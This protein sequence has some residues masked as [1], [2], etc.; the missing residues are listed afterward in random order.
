M[1]RNLAT[2]NGTMSPIMRMDTV[3]VA[4]SDCAIR[5]FCGTSPYARCNRI[6]YNHNKQNGSAGWT[7][8]QQSETEAGGCRIL[9]PNSTVLGSSTGIRKTG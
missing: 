2:L 3:R 8:S 5:D 7:H 4:V 9:Q 6:A 1:S